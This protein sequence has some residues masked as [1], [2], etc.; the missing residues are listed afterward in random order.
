LIVNLHQPSDV[1][2][3]PRGVVPTDRDGEQ[4]YREED[5]VSDV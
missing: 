1:Y 4:L 2:G 3:D 5:A